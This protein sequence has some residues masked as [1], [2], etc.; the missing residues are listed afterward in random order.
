[1]YGGADLIVGTASVRYTDYVETLEDA[2][3]DGG[4]FTF[5]F[6]FRLGAEYDINENIGVF[7]NAERSV[8]QLTDPAALNW[9]ND[10]GV[11]VKYEF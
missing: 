7:I 11:G 4:G 2:S 5:G 6:R 3:Y 10:Y 9:V 8:W 1:M